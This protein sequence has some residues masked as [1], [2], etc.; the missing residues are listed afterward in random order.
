MPENE[1]VADGS[2]GERPDAE[3]L[4]FQRHFEFGPLWNAHGMWPEPWW[5][6]ARSHPPNT[7]EPTEHVR[8]SAFRWWLTQPLNDERLNRLIDLM[9]L[10][11]DMSMAGAALHQ[12]LGLPQATEAHA[13]RFQASTARSSKWRWWYAEKPNYAVQLWHDI[14]ADQAKRRAHA[15]TLARVAA[16]AQ[17]PQPQLSVGELL[18]LYAQD[19]PSLMLALI[20]HPL[21]PMAQ[22]QALAQWRDRAQ[23]KKVRTAAEWAMAQRERATPTPDA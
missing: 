14:R 2:L 12:L 19:D 16:D 1:P 7:N 9:A 21:L 4:A 5:A 23:A 6:E 17:L 10:D 15:D 11:S 18:D 13:Q 22:L 20:A 8:Y 3:R